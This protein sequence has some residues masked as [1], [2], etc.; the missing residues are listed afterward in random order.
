MSFFGEKFDHW[1]DLSLFKEK[2]NIATTGSSFVLAM[3]DLE[4]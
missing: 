1:L 3:G 2:R 4:G